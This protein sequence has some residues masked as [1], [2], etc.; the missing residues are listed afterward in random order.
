[1]RVLLA[2]GHGSFREGL[3]ALLS[4]WPGIEVVG[5]ASDGRQAVRLALELVPDLVLLEVGMA[6]LDGMEATRRIR[7][8]LPLTRVVA[9]SMH[10]DQRYVVGMLAAG[11]SGYVVKDGSL[12]ELERAVCVVHSGGRYLSP[13]IAGVVVDDHVRRLVTAQGSGVE[14]LSPR[15]REVLELLAKGHYTKA[16]ADRLRL[17]HKTVA[18]HRKSIT[19]KLDL[20]TVAELTKFAVRVG[21]KTPKDRRVKSP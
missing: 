5:E 20:H 17:S 7:A 12:E 13:E 19:A 2:D 15:E 3:R 18:A 16:I 14:K 4:T 9:L 10:A 8:Q 11:A 1:M 21:V 6:G